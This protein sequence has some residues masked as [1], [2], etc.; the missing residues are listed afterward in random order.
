MTTSAVR[1]PRSAWQGYSQSELSVGGD[2]N[3]RH[4]VGVA[5]ERAVGVT[6]LVLP[7]LQLPH[8]D[9]PIARGRHDHVLVLT[10]TIRWQHAG[11]QLH[12]IIKHTINTHTS[13]TRE[14]DLLQQCCCWKE[15]PYLFSICVQPEQRYWWFRTSDC[16]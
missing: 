8:D 2:D 9:A 11:K 7:A 1:A 13:S 16:P 4:E 10:S 15:P 5:R 3:F 14:S 12:V 6:V